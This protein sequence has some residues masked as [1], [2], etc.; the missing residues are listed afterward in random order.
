MDYKTMRGYSDILTDYG[1]INL[2]RAVE[3]KTLAKTIFSTL[4]S[5]PK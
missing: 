1:R 5:P 4:K 3:V 2:Y